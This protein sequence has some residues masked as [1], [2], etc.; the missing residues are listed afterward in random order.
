ML[1][2]MDRWLS[3]AE[4]AF[5]AFMIVTASFLLFANVVGRYVFSSAIIG[6]EE[7]VRYQIVWLV[8]I[9]SSV[10]ARKGIHIGIDA[11]LKMSP[12]PVARIISLIA[13]TLCVVFCAVLCVYG[14]ELVMATYSFGQR[15]S[16]LRLP[17]WLAMLAI[18]VG[19][20]LMTLRFTQRLVVLWRG[21]AGR[22]D[23]EIIG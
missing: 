10:A 4:E 19:A 2:H 5:I 6:A 22:A 8:F 17:F 7:L 3:R 11:F 1:S 23:V 9:G 13:L 21:E 16:A 18:P 20:G 15:S 12:A 14:V